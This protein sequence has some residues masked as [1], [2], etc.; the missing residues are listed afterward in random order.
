MPPW[1]LPSNTLRGTV[2]VQMTESDDDVRAEP[3]GFFV[4]GIEAG[5]RVAA[6]RYAAK[7]EAEAAANQRAKTRFGP[8]F[9]IAIES[10]FVANSGWEPGPNR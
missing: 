10:S 8:V 6:T 3:G 5:G 1:N 2:G 9:V 7:S 4:L